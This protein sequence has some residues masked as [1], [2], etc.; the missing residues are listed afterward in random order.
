MVR[1]SAERVLLIGDADHEVRE[2]LLQAVPA[3]QVTSVSSVFEGI[4]ELSGGASGSAAAGGAYT[5]VI[6]AAEP[7][8][9]RAEAA[10]RTLRDVGGNA[11]LVLFGTAHHEIL[12]RRMRS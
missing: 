10:V 11:R 3:A 6:A 7:I 2:A 5:A 12:S 8:E 1:P 4:A 9:R